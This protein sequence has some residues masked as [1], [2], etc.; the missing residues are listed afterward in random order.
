MKSAGAHDRSFER[1]RALTQALAHRFRTPLSVI[2]ND[3]TY[4]KSTFKSEDFDRGIR[5]CKELSEQLSYICSFFSE[6]DAPQKI[7]LGSEVNFLLG[8]ASERLSSSPFRIA[9]STMLDMLFESAALS[10]IATFDRVILSGKCQ[11]SLNASAQAKVYDSFTELFFEGLG[12]DLIDA[13]LFDT[14]ISAQGI[15]AEINLQPQSI[16]IE[17][18]RKAVRSSG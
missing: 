13:P 6:C 2:S 8:K 17:L 16:K 12:Q 7:D 9:L 14:L 5:R 15:C 1:L 18:V 10:E 4:F 3:L 11:P